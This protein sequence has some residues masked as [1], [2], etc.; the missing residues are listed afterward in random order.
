MV[1]HTDV[2][3]HLTSLA[4]DIAKEKRTVEDVRIVAGRRKWKRKENE[5]FQSCK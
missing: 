2:Y 3:K 4:N 1:V 5:V